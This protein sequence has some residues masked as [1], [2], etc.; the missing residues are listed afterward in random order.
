MFS[1]DRDRYVGRP[2]IF[3]TGSEQNVQAYGQ[4]RLI[5]TPRYGRRLLYGMPGNRS[6]STVSQAGQGKESRCWRKGEGALRI[7]EAPLRYT[8]PGI[9][10]HRTRL[11]PNASTI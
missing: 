9:A 4:P 11:S 3:Q 8:A 1:G 5:N 2:K 7:S 6:R 10:S